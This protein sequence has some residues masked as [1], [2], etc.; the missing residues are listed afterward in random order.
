MI[1]SLALLALPLLAQAKIGLDG[2]EPYTYNASPSPLFYCPLTGEICD[3]LECGSNSQPGCPGYTGPSSYKPSYVPSW[4]PPPSHPA[5]SSPAV[6]TWSGK[7]T[8]WSSAKET[9]TSKVVSSTLIKVGPTGGYSW[10]AAP[11]NGT[12]PSA[13]AS[14]KP[15]SSLYVSAAS[16]IAPKDIG[17]AILLAIAGLLMM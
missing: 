8:T 1:Y 12:T 17:S 15:S 13:V 5:T 16:S 4:T 11:T 14:A 2:C 10:V 9:S 7:P 3:I 6:P